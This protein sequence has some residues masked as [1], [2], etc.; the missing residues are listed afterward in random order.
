MLFRVLNESTYIK[1]LE[2]FLVHRKYL[3]KITY[4]YP[5]LERRH[6]NEIFPTYITS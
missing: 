4:Y 6:I 1:N 3:L 2:E 5:Q